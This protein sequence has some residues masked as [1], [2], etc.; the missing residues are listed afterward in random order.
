M[1]RIVLILLS[2]VST[3]DVWPQRA[4]T[5]WQP[6][7]I[8]SLGQGIGVSGV[9]F[10]KQSTCVTLVDTLG[11]LRPSTATY[12]S[13]EED[14]HYQLTHSECDT[15][16]HTITLYF[17]AL[18]QTTRL[19]DLC[20]DDGRQTWRWWGLHSAIRTILLPAT[21]PQYDADV[22]LS[23]EREAL[24]SECSLAEALA[25]DTV[26]TMVQR[27]LPAYRNYI[28]WKWKLTA[29][30]QFVV[31]QAME[32]SFHSRVVSRATRANTH[33]YLHDGHEPEQPTTAQANASPRKRSLFRRLFGGSGKKRLEL[34]PSTTL[35][36][37][38]ALSPFE[39]K[40]LQEIRK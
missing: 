19:M 20:V 22:T 5:M 24:L 12:A 18:P 11:L 34:E 36:Q 35:R 32:T 14:M 15:A 27:N 6:V 4:V 2:L 26:R 17:N 8:L 10:G 21:R 16:S 28:A 29:H 9:T 25:I 30:E 13:D 33:A 38:R 7:A 40:M 23:A 3:L 1:K 37:Q 39:Q 31:Q